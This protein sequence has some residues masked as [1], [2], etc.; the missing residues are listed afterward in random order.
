MMPTTKE[1]RPGATFELESLP[2]ADRIPAVAL[3]RIERRM[4]QL[5]QASANPTAD[6]RFCPICDTLS[7]AFLPAGIVP[8]PQA[9]CP[10]C[11][12]LERHRLTWCFLTSCTRLLQAPTRLLHFAP[13]ACLAQAFRRAPGVRYLS[14]DIQPGAADV[15][16]DIANLEFP[17]AAFAAIYCS[18]VLEHIADDARAMRQMLRVL[19][20]GG[21]ALIALPVDFTKAASD[22]DP[23]ASAEERLK[24]FGDTL[25]VRYYGCDVIQRL[26]AAGFL[27]STFTGF[28][29]LLSQE[30]QAR[31]TAR[32]W[33]SFFLCTKK[34]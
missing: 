27:V 26:N 8:R 14:A 16:A 24:R 10:N 30:L 20:P 22:E 17:D 33:E 4:R 19:R 13:E 29:H 1:D 25:H 12:S 2:D 11:G 34:A 23:A 6:H 5:R 9:L 32:S 31:I 15:V 18:H 7:E 28:H 21:W 3:A